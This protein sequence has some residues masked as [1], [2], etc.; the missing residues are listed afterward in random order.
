MEYHCTPKLRLFFGFEGVSR[1]IMASLSAQTLIATII[2][3]HYFD[4]QYD[5]DLNRKINKF[6]SMCGVISITLEKN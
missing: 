4:V 1:V 3:V 5:E 2:L 6:Q